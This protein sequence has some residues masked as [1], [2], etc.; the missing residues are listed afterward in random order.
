MK[1]IQI[2]VIIAI[3]CCSILSTVLL[4]YFS[5]TSSTRIAKADANQ[6]MKILSES[7]AQEVNALL[8]RIGQSVD[9]LSDIALS[10]MK[11][12]KFK[13]DPEYVKEYTES[14]E[15]MVVK[16]SENTEG[17]VC[18]YVR[19]NPDFTEPTSGIFLTRNSLDEDFKSVVPTD[20]SIYDKTDLAHVG[21]YYIPVENKAPI[22]MAPYFNE[23]VDMY[24][25]SYVVP[26]YVNGESIGVIG[27]DI[28]FNTITNKVGDISLYD[29]GYAFLLGQDN[30]IMFHKDYEVGTSLA[31]I[32]DGELEDLEKQI[33]EGKNEKLLSYRYKRMKKSLIYSNLDNGMK[34][35]LTVPNKEINAN[36]NRLTKQIGGFSIVII[37]LGSVIGIVMGTSIS[38]P[39]KK[40]TRVLKQTA[41]FDF[42]D[43]DIIT[44]LM[45]HKDEIGVMAREVKKMRRS[46]RDVTSSMYNIKENVLGNV[47]KLDG[48]MS[49]NND[50]SEENST[51]IEEISAKMQ[52]TSSRASIISEGVEQVKSNSS[53]IAELTRQGKERS[54][55]VMDRAKELGVYTDRSNAETL[56]IFAEM[57]EKA[58]VA[59]EQSKS[60]QRINELT[61][62]IKGISSQTN[63]LALNA[64]IE[65]A[66]AG[67]A[68][69][70]FAVVATEI[71][72]LANETYTAIEDINGIVDEV[73]EAVTNMSDCI[74]MLMQFLERKVLK[75]YK[76]FK[77]S[78]DEYLKDAEAVRLIVEGIDQS[79]KNLDNQISEISSGVINISETVEYTALNIS[80]V[81]DKISDT[82][83]KSV[84]GYQQLI[85]SRESVDRLVELVQQFKTE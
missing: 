71:G 27:M 4:S 10:Q 51:V 75:D 61:D 7:E 3:L 59:I 32:E 79:M 26:L 35:V 34:L 52:E 13:K 45:K 14:I 77:D 2:K 16:F 39:I 53:E 20:F 24:M 5:L 17:V 80:S 72:N 8:S 69:K 37:I 22:W 78:G 47:E 44:Q 73:T 40:I 57:Q 11:V 6:T 1:S 66:R 30:Q 38:N 9:T 76:S 42:R 28:D 55:E 85:E 25:I 36:A 23:N 70:G 67:E 62:N 49:D 82:V 56:R 29:N 15:E 12:S 54:E 50:I 58:N 81:A 68:G 19:Y 63:L 43:S 65:A 33:T 46:L 21:W 64:N 41:E 84:D 48:M 31:K 83:T 74:Q 60:V 18:S